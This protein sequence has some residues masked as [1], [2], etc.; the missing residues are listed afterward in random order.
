M[1]DYRGRRVA[2]LGSSGFV[3]RW[4]ALKAAEYGAETMLL[5]R[6]REN[7]R[8]V[9]DAFGVEGNIVEIDLFDANKAKETLRSMKPVLII[10]LAGYGVAR[11]ERNVN[12]MFQINS[13][14][15]QKVCEA[16]DWE[17]D[18]TW[19]GQD[20]VHA[21]S[22]FEYGLI[23]GDLSEESCPRPHTDYGRSKLSGTQRLEECG[24]QGRVRAIVARIFTVYGPGENEGRLLPTL[25]RCSRS[26]E[27]VELTSGSQ[28][29]DF[30]YVEDVA[31]GILRLGTT[32]GA[33]VDIVNLATGRLTS[34]K[35]FVN[36]AA[37]ILGLPE[38][39]LAFGAIPDHYV[40]MEHDPV[41][42]RK[43]KR[44]TGWHPSTN[45]KEGIRRTMSF[46]EAAFGN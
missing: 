11:D 14:A 37:K 46:R 24:R 19:H 26:G 45:L 7:S 6:N 42:T 16:I 1:E 29:R 41:N 34:V 9:F 33:G 10:N 30:T 13:D 22:A 36:E 27:N 38:G 40:E 35:T 23:H 28:F 39:Q 31:E 21:G 4:V 3:G 18:K 44:L 17:R 20:M 12:T 25:V 5:V 8:K 2:I 15:V 43:L 32:G